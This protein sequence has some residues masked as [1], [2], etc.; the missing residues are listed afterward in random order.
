MQIGDYEI[1]NISIGD[2]DAI[3][4]YYA[5]EVTWS[6]N[7][8]GAFKMR[9]SMGEGDWTFLAEDNMTWAQWLDSQ[10]NTKG[11]EISFGSISGGGETLYGIII[12]Y[13]SSSSAEMVVLG[14]TSAAQNQTINLGTNYLMEYKD[15]SEK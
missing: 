7:N 13:Y 9:D 14:D 8:I 12:D 15:L 6:K 3:A 1:T 2:I 4:V 5:G 11:S 10:Y